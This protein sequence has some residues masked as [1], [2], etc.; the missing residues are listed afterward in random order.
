[1]IFA[2][3]FIEFIIVD[4]DCT[5][6][7]SNAIKNDTFLYNYIPMSFIKCISSVIPKYL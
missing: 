5:H 4:I 3:G 7:P 2:K 1:M 6:F